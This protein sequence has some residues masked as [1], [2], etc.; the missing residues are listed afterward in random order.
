MGRLLERGGYTSKYYRLLYFF[1]VTLK[2]MPNLAPLS[3][4]DAEAPYGVKSTEITD[5]LNSVI[6]N[7]PRQSPGIASSTPFRVMPDHI[8]LLILVDGSVPAAERLTLPQYVRV[9][10]RRL[11]NAFNEVTGH[12]GEVFEWKWHD[13]VVKKERQLANFRHYIINNAFMALARARRL[14]Y[15]RIQQIEHA[16]L[17][18]RFWALGNVE[19]LDYPE[20]TALKVSRTVLPETE[21]WA[22]EVDVFRFATPVDVVMSC[23]FSRGEQ[24]VRWYVLA[25]GGGCVVLLPD[26]F[27]SPLEVGVGIFKWHPAGDRLQQACAEGRL[28]F[29]SRMAPKV[30]KVEKVG[31]LRERCLQMNALAQRLA[32]RFSKR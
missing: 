4:L 23:F 1:M 10:R 24:A 30:K 13:Y 20:L 22:R 27:E 15:F 14:D 9:L 32:E 12:Q 26:G 17:P 7:F 19:I 2:R 25:Q 6:V 28:L 5:A 8:H 3:L 21:T 16:R 11:T 29:L 18:A 31:S